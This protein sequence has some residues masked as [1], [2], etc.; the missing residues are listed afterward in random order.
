MK[1][2]DLVKFTPPQIFES[3]KREYASPGIIIEVRNQQTAAP[4]F[5]SVY[6]VRWND[7]RITNEHECYIGKIS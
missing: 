4:K 1:V 6:T 2:G 5:R 7:G 3:A